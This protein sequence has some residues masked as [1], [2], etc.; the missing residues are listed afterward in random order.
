M[1]TLL[2]SA[3]AAAPAALTLV[4][5]LRLGAAG[6]RERRQSLLFDLGLLMLVLAAA[7]RRRL[8]RTAPAGS[9]AER[10]GA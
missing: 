2:F 4:L 6:R 7:T 3:L 5:W 9:S 10:A 8:A 1:E